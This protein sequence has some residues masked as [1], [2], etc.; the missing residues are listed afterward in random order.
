M[1]PIE[2]IAGKR[3]LIV[4]DEKDVLDSLA[5]LLDMCKID[6]AL[7]F[8]EGRRFLDE[9]DYDVAIL[10]IMGVNGFDLLETAR[11]RDIPALMLTA[12]GLS[13]ENLKRSAQNGASYYAPKEE[14]AN[15]A[16][17]VA[18]VLEARSKDKSP[19]IKWFERLGRYY[20][21]RFGGKDWREKE[22]DFWEKRVKALK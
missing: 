12:H 17:F 15:I 2:M 1:D 16:L 7:T 14:M 4:D 9:N 13:E 21:R 6:A 22:K 10:D 5:N 19:W 8:E 20:D 18:D 11:K 3:V